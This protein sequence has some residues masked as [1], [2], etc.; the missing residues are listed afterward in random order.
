VLHKAQGEYAKAETLYRRA[1][2]MYEGLYPKGRYPHGHPDLANSITNLAALHQ[3]QGKHARAE[4]LFRRA[5]E[6]YA[7]SAAALAETAAEATG[8]NYL[9]KLPA[10]RDGYLA[11][12]K[13]PHKG[14]T[15]LAVWQ[16]KAALSR[17]YERRHLAV[18][19]ASSTEARSLWNSILALHR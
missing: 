12:T 19:A 1:L 11:V 18:L 3:E 6:M 16:S 17:L 13:P 7:A 2:Q 5:L 8:L 14:D 9:A 15:Y 4:P 10:T